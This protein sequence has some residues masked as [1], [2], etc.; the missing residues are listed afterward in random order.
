M[1]DMISLFLYFAKN[2]SV[3]RFS[4]HNPA[5]HQGIPWGAR[6]LRRI[7]T[8]TSNAITRRSAHQR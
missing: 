2:S 4:S 6:Q 3:S 7:F 5:S 1:S 8:G